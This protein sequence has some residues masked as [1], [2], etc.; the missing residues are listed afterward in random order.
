ME[1]LTA[2]AHRIF[3]GSTI[4][5]TET[6]EIAKERMLSWIKSLKEWT[7]AVNRWALACEG[8][9]QA[10]TLPKPYCE[11][12]DRLLST[13]LTDMLNKLHAANLA[14]DYP[15]VYPPTWITRPTFKI[16][17][18]MDTFKDQIFIQSLG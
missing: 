7:D 11:W 10:L 18:K 15:T 1:E 14:Q 5:M 4:I 6:Y 13:D 16:S 9:W 8:A 3:P 17:D 2:R 12:A